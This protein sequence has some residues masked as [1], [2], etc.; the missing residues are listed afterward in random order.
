MATSTGSPTISSEKQRAKLALARIEAERERRSFGTFLREVNPDWRWDW[1]Y[2]VRVR[3]HLEA[4]ARGECRR[5]M[6]FLPPRHGKSSIATI[7]FPVW[8]L[9]RSPT[10]RVIVGCYNQDL[11]KKFTRDAR[12]IARDRFPLGEVDQAQE[13]ETAA[14]GSMRAAGVGVGITGHGGD[15]IV[16]DDPVK[17]REEA[18]SR[19]YRDGVWDWYTN[20]LYPRQEPGAAIVLMMTRW[21]TDDLAGRILKSGEASEWT[22][23]HLPALALENDQLGRAPGEA[24]CPER[25]SVADLERIRRAQSTESEQGEYAFQAL[26]QGMPTP[27]E[28]AFFKVDQFDYVDAAPPGLRKVRAWDEGATAGGGDPSAGVRMEGPDGSGVYYVVHVERGR[29]DPSERDKRQRKTADADG[30]EV[31]VRGQQEPGSA[32]KSR[33]DAFVRLLAGYSV[34][35]LPATGDK[36]TRADPFAS[37]VN[38]GKVRLVRGT[39]N[40]EYVEELRTFP[41]GA[42]DDQVDASADAFDELSRRP[43]FRAYLAG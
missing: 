9:E 1:P 37:Q 2:L 17:S 5:L 22:V 3:E 29:W 18:E 11:A 27:R 36:A 25:Y 16:I 23:I 33:A 24:L 20:D 26:Y 19:A 34:T 4:V 7:R 21:H 31:K 8:R 39:W 6:V 30:R 43:S 15:L 41:L 10:L 42:H 28:G 40:A 12:R 14:G 32:G 38:A 13:W 35:V